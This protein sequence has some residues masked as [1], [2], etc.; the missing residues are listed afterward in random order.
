MT[1]IPGVAPKQVSI[2]KLSIFVCLL[3]FT[4]PN[5]EPTL[6]NTQKRLWISTLYGEICL[7]YYSF[8]FQP[9]ASAPIDSL[10]LDNILQQWPEPITDPR[11][12][13]KP[14]DFVISFREI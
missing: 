1:S 2:Q 6:F 8:Y 13:I 11:S 4:K 3:L 12:Q 5:Q 10:P 7:V 9:S 14:K